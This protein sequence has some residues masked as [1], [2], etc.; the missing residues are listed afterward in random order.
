VGTELLLGQIVNTN[1]QRISKALASVGVDVFFHTVV[2]DNLTRATEAISNALA[3]S[4]VAVVTGGL[5]PTPDDLTR[6][7]V[8]AATDRPLHRDDAIARWI[9]EF[10]EERG[11]SM[12]EE[13]LKQAD[14][15]A[16]AR[17]IRPRGTA[18]GFYLEFDSKLLFALPGVPWEMEAMLE[19]TVVPELRRRTGGSVTLSKEVLVI[20]LGES[21]THE[22]IA[23]IVAAQ[24]NPTVAYLAG[25]GRVRVRVTAKATTEDEAGALI[26]P[27][28]DAVRARLG[29][30]AVPGDGPLAEALGELL[31]ERG[32]TV[33]VAESLTGGLIATEL[34]EMSGAS[35]Y[36]AGSIV[37]YRDDAKLKLPAF[38]PSILEGPGAVSAES[39]A[40][41]AQGAAGAFGADLGLSAT[42]VAG[43]N[44]QEGK[45]VGTIYVGACFEGH[46]DVREVRGY[47]D[48]RNVQGIAVT[49]ALNLGRLVLQRAQ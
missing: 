44:E 30:A 24:S 22:K 37:T 46:T 39:A 19:D 31:R 36:F 15:P 43:P 26:A 18:P 11:R 21:H 1:A 16:G 13:N 45:P 12:P 38:D 32:L 7:A 28:E 6:E 34:T 35:D 5:G 48:R 27:I 20:G 4:D 41:L 47:G 25:R 42:G 23:D 49:A 29:E 2:G 10:F 33:A 8:A 14:L 40:A 9:R 3:R 17:P